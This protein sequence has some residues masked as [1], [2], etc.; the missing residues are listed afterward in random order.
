MR[1][2]FC[3]IQISLMEEVPEAL[4]EPRFGRTTDECMDIGRAQIAIPPEEFEYLNVALGK[5]KAFSG[6]SPAHS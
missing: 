2:T 1:R 6:S 4:L 3:T 5:L